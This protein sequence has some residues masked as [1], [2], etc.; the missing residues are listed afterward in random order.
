[1][2]LISRNGYFRFIGVVYY[3]NNYGYSFSLIMFLVSLP[4]TP[5]LLT[6]YLLK[7]AIEWIEWKI[8][9]LIY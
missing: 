8:E 4:F 3:N 6:I 5:I 9:R 2:N 7:E 1:M